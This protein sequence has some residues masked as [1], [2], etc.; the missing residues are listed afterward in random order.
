MKR[1]MLA[2]LF[3]VILMTVPAAAGLL[4][5]HAENAGNQASGAYEFELNKDG[6][7]TITNYETEEW[8]WDEDAY[9]EIIEIPAEL[10]GHPVTVIGAQTP[11]G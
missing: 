10:D 4:T 11:E 7:A 9:D 1:R 2:A 5:A 8:R 3:A 6:T